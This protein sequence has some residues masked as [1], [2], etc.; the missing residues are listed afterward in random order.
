MIDYYSA[1]ATQIVFAGI[2]LAIFIPCALIAIKM[3]YDVFRWYILG[4]D[5]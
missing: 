1:I 5:D 4:K 2:V 3:I